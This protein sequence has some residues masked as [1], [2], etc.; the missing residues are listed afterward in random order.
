[1]K[2]LKNKK[3]S[4]QNQFLNLSCFS[5]TANTAGLKNYTDFSGTTHFQD[6]QVQTHNFEVKLHHL[7]I[8]SNEFHNVIFYMSIK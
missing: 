2:I 8:L 7:H 3:K 1:V 5:V 6:L 4:I